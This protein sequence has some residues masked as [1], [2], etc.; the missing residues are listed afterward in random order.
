MTPPRLFAADSVFNKPVDHANFVEDPQSAGIVSMLGDYVDSPGVGRTAANP[1]LYRVVQE[2]AN[3][4][5]PIVIVPDDQPLIPFDLNLTYHW[6]AKQALALEL[7]KGVPIPLGT[8]PAPGTDGHL[9]IWQPGRDFLLEVWQYS[10]SGG[11]GRGNLAGMTRAASKFSGV[12]SGSLG[13]TATSLSVAGGVLRIDEM[14]AWRPGTPIPHALAL[15]L[16]ANVVRKGWCDPATR[17][18]G[19]LT[20][21]TTIP[22]GARLV[23]P[24]DYP[25]HLLGDK[26]K[27]G[28]CATRMVAE[29]AQR[30]G[31]LLRDR[32]ND[33][34]LIFGEQPSGADAGKNLYGS[35]SSP[36]VPGFW[37]NGYCWEWLRRDFP[38][39]SLRLEKMVLH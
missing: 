15:N 38:W 6:T 13:A 5:T 20:G 3:Y 39:R 21:T 32:T 7:A 18:D 29:M 25:V 4:S 14:R 36:R 8:K 19:T 9:V 37:G 10:E 26:A 31:F 35:N 27:G 17:G 23:L 34:V 24:A 2:W 33:G 11:R 1:N 22:E 16:G 30:Y 12:Y 28:Y